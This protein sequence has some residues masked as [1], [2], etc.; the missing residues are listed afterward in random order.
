MV[1]LLLM[2]LQSYGGWGNLLSVD[3]SLDTIFNQASD[4]APLFVAELFSDSVQLRTGRN[5]KKGTGI[6]SRLKS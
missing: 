2:Y 5:L 1:A 6:S 3:H 4:Q